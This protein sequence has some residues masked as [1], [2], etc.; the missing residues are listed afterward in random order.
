MKRILTGLLLL[1]FSCVCA[2]PEKFTADE[3]KNYIDGGKFY[4][5]I[6]FNWVPDSCILGLELI[7]CEVYYEKSN[8]KTHIFDSLMNA[9]LNVK[10]GET[11]D[12][13]KQECSMCI[14]EYYGKYKAT[15]IYDLDGDI[16]DPGTAQR[17]IDQGKLYYLIFGSLTSESLPDGYNE[18]ERE[19]YEGLGLKI[20]WLGGATVELVPSYN[21][22]MFS[23]LDSLNGTIGT[24]KKATKA[25]KECLENWDKRK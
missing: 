22:Y 25:F 2:Q 10:I 14:M 21:S 8:S 11:W 1:T 5:R 17:H 24:E 4:F 15:R 19:V 23:Y 16:L 9:A 13:I 3:A 12:S 6:P 7:D 20:K 18:C